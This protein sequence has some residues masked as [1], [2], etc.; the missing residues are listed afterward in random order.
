MAWRDS[1]VGSGR[2]STSIGPKARDRL[3]P[4]Q[5]ELAGDPQ[6]LVTSIAEQADMTCEVDHI[7]LLL[8]RVA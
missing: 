1:S 8:N 4:S 7:K 6:R 2:C 3:S 5:L